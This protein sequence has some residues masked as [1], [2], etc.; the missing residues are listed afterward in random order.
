MFVTPT[1]TIPVGVTFYQ[2]APE[3]SAWYK[4]ERKL[5]H[6]GVAK[7]QRPPKPP[8]NPHYPTKQD[9]ALR[10][11]AQFKASHPALHVHCIVADALYGTA[12]FVDGASAIF[13]GAQVIDPLPSASHQAPKASGAR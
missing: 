2:P 1:I 12:P 8:P 7:T 11:L 10:L 9:L 3:L 13:G 5:K 6:Q 4:Q